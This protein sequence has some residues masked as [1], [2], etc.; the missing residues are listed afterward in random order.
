MLRLCTE[1]DGEGGKKLPGCGR[2]YD[3]VQRSTICPHDQIGL[4]GSYCRTHD[5][6]HCHLCPPKGSPLLT[7]QD[8]CLS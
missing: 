8:T 5:L 6:L 3:D 1:Q 7:P 4:G 2:V